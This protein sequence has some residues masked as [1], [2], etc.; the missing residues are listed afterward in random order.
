MIEVAVA[1]VR[2][3]GR[4]RMLLIAASTA[5]ASALLMVA[6]A[7]VRLPSEPAENLFNL[8]DEPGLRPGTVSGTVLLVLPLLLLLYQAV[9]LGTATRERRLAALRVAGATPRQVRRL[10]S[11]EVGVPVLAGAIA[12]L[13]LYG[14][15]RVV[16]GGTPFSDVDEFASP[17]PVQLVP[18]TVTPSWWQFLAI[19]GAVT[20]VGILVGARASRQVVVTPLGVTRR[21]ARRAPRPWGLVLVGAAAVLGAIGI[22]APLPRDVY[23]PLGIAVVLS[24]V[25]GVVMLAPWF[26]Y[27]IGCRLS[28]R[29]GSPV[30]LLAA[31][32]LVAEPRPAGRAAAAAGAIGLVAGGA[33]GLGAEVAVGNEWDSF[34]VTSFALVGAALLVALVVTTSALAV[35]A[36]ESLLDRRR[37]MAAL[38]AAGTEVAV[39]HAAQRRAAV[40]VAVPLV[41]AGSFF[42]ALVVGMTGMSPVTG[43]VSSM[44]AI[45]AI[46]LLTWA[47][48]YLAAGIVKPSLVRA[49]APVNLRT[50]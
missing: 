29:T 43:V 34:F 5:V 11:L 18:T 33:G 50:E 25:L 30:T 41:A 3:S 21:Q 1:F 42:G 7:I 35:H 19:I 45:V 37:A 10:G 48:A 22:A 13:P 40:L 28:H 44:P 12:G 6:V 31:R 36:V 15:L 17:A 14:L 8:V 20:A 47:A 24:V 38:V 49:T 2:G 26:A 46:V 16:F 23:T 27:R 9:R 4:A 39:I 32:Q